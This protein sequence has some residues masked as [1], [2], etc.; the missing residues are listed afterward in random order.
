MMRK[1]ALFTAFATVI[2]LAACS[3]DNKEDS[4]KMPWDDDLKPSVDPGKDDGEVKVGD[5]LPLWKEG[6]LDIH[7]V[8]TGRGECTFLVFPDGTSMCIDA[9]EIGTKD[10]SSYKMVPQRPNSSTRAYIT[11]GNY[12][13]HFLPA[14]SKYVLDYFLLSHFHNDHYGTVTETAYDMDAKGGYRV[15]G[16]FGLYSVV[17]FNKLVDRIYPNYAE[18]DNSSNPSEAG[19]WKNGTS[20]YKKFV[21]YNTK[22]SG[23]KVEKFE[24]GSQS[25]FSLL[26]DPKTYSNFKVRNVCSNGCYWD[27]SKSVNT[28]GSAQLTENGASN[29][30]LISYGKFDYLSCGDAGQN[31]KVENP[32]AQSLDMRLEAMKAHHHM[33][34]NTMTTSALQIYRPQVIVTQSFYERPED[35]PN[36]SVLSNVL[37]GA[38]VGTK[39]LYFTNAAGSAV[40]HPELYGNEACKSTGGHVVIR[41]APGG[42]SFMVYVLDDT[43]TA[44]RIKR[45]DGPFTCN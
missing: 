27:G 43:D 5:T 17:K 35:Q 28:F 1:A 19:S 6:C 39:Y 38:Y 32:L 10:P 11:Y 40:I 15:V 22:S 21:D 42:D 18:V 24:L 33:S 8:N 45:I 12:I 2:L 44:F 4:G 23:L 29:G 37:G 14:S 9:G 16:M 3:K 26:K 31:G 20:H 30:V 25:Q 7:A 13:K 34:S 41:V 36:A